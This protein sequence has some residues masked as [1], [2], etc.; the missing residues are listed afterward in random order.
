MAR[1]IHSRDPAWST[2]SYLQQPLV[3]SITDKSGMGLNRSAVRV[4]IYQSIN[5]LI[6]ESINESINM[7]IFLGYQRFLSLSRWFGNGH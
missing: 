3:G 5:Q 2:S 4:Q 6:N 7:T 1:I